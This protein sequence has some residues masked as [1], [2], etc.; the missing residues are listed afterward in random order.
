M[1]EI[2]KTE[3]EPFLA[4]GE[5]RQATK[6]GTTW[7]EVIHKIAIGILVI[8]GLALAAGIICGLAKLTTAVVIPL[9]GLGFVAAI[10]GIV[11]FST[12]GRYTSGW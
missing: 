10:V 2:P 8:A 11:L 6:E 5:L 12:Y 7:Q 3:V 9:I 4:S 1:P